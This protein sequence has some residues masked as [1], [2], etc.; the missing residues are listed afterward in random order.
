DREMIGQS[1]GSDCNRAAQ[2][3]FYLF[4]CAA[5]APKRTASGG[6]MLALV[7]RPVEDTGPLA[8]LLAARGV[9]TVSEPL[10]AIRPIAGAAP[11][12][13]GVQAVLFTSANGARAFAAAVA[14][15]NLPVFAP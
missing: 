3:S 12:L 4:P 13:D 9:V 10:L 8:D 7:T 15:R 6:G 11:D 14:P 5:S 2:V 1:R